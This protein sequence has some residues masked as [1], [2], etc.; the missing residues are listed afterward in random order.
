MFM[1]PAVVAAPVATPATPGT[2]TCTPPD[3]IHAPHLGVCRCRC[4]LID[5]GLNDGQSVREWARIAAEHSQMMVHSETR[6][7]MRACVEDASTCYYG[8]EANP[9]FTPMLSQLERQ[10][11]VNGTSMRLF[12]ET[13]FNTRGGDVE[14]LVEPLG[15]GATGSTLSGSKFQL[16]KTYVKTRVHSMDAGHFLR[17]VARASDFIAAKIDIEGFE[18]ELLQYLLDTHA[19]AT[20]AI[21]VAAIEWHGRMMPKGSAPTG[22]LKYR[23]RRMCNTTLIDWT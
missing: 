20:C 21:R 16:N 7:Q 18:Y 14:F 6:A 5:V 11:R 4:T 22:Q 23:L 15:A 10:Q 19:E 17:A 1:T 8:F 9:V 13:A 3:S 2:P 12:T